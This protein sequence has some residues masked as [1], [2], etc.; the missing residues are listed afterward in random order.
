V[1]KLHIFITNI[2]KNSCAK[3]IKIVQLTIQHITGI[4][5][6]QLPFTSLVAT[7][8]QDNLVRFIDT[9]VENISLKALGF[10]D[11]TIKSETKHEKIT[12]FLHKKKE[13]C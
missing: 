2:H 7:I 13:A 8:A 10:T 4:P 11:K 1:K 5:R 9:F 3:N 12:L 6:N